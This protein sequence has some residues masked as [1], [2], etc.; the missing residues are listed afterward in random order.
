MTFCSSSAHALALSELGNES[1]L[2]YVV[3]WKGQPYALPGSYDVRRVKIYNFLEANGED[4]DRWL[5]GV[6]RVANV[7]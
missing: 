3:Y 7:N 6:L 2:E 4:V 1:L 5:V